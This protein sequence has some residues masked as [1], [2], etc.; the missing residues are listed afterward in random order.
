MN[1]SKTLEMLYRYFTVKE[2]SRVVHVLHVIELCRL[3]IPVR[4]IYIYQDCVI[5]SRLHDGMLGSINSTASFDQDCIMNVSILSWILV[6]IL[7]QAYKD[8]IK[9]VNVALLII[10]QDLIMHVVMASC[11]QYYYGAMPTRLYYS[12]MHLLW[13]HACYQSTAPALH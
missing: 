8:Y 4:Y 7:H 5:R 1:L 12:N 3:G 6:L 2:I 9:H 13:H 11:I 10:D